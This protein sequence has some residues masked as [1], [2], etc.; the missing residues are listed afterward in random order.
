MPG[1]MNEIDAR[2][3]NVNDRIDALRREIREDHAVL[4]ARLRDVQVEFAKVDQRL[5]T[6]ERV[7]LPPAPPAA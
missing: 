6:V 3:G 7:V 5:A 2:I 4:D 1:T